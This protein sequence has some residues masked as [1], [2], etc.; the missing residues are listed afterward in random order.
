MKPGSSARKQKKRCSFQKRTSVSLG[1]NTSNQSTTKRKSDFS[2]KKTAS[3]NSSA[4]GSN[5]PPYATGYSVRE[6]GDGKRR[7]FAPFFSRRLSWLLEANKLMRLG[8]LGHG[9]HHAICTEPHSRLERACAD[10]MGGMPWFLH[11]MTLHEL[12]LPNSVDDLPRTL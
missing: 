8:L 12:P 3:E 2:L 10:C 5:H 9:Q 7:T 4:P 11:C 1:R 6:V